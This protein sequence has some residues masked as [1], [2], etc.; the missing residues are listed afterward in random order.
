MLGD[1]CTRDCGFCAVA[2]GTPLPPDPDEPARVAEA[3]AA[4]GLAYAV[5]TS[6]TR[7]DL[8]DGGAAHFAAVIRAI[9]A[10]SPDTRV[11]ALIPDFGGDA[12]A[13]GDGPRRR[14]RTSSTTTWRRRSRSIRP[15]AGPGRTIAARSASSAAAKARGAR[16]KSGLMIGLGESEADI[17][18]TFADL[19]Q[20]GCDLLTVGQYLQP[21]AAHPPV[22]KYY[23]PGGI[24]GPR[25]GGPPG[26]LPGGRLGAARPQLLRGRTALRRRSAKRTEPHALPDLHRHPRQ[27]RGLPCGPQGRPEEK[28]RP[29]HLPRRPRRLRGLAERGH[30]EDPDPQAPVH[31]PGQPRQGRLRPRLRPDLQS[32]RRV[33]HLLDQEDDRPEEPRLPGP[34]EAEPRGRPGDHHHLPRRALRRGLLHL[35]RVRR[36]RGLLLHPDAGLLLRPH[37]LPLRLHRQGRQRRGHRSSRATPTR[38]SSRRASAISSIPAR[39]ASPGTAIPGPP[40]PSTTPR[41]GPIKFSRVEYDIEEAKR[42]IIDEQLPP[43]LAERL[44]LGI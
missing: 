6:V 14:G 42:K 23:T 11:E 28:D 33:G 26:R 22:A 20:A 4:L 32:H 9:R 34:A 21:T 37:P 36:R 24:R 16:T 31:H 5:V 44:S 8:P 17:L 18:R 12:A 19:R 15:S 40:S 7:D 2:K 38:S 29:L 3:V 25:G 35:R 43:A 1:T 41:P 39:S 30:P 10:E 27:P 13:L